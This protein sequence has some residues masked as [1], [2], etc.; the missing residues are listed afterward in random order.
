MGLRVRDWGLVGSAPGPPTHCIQTVHQV[1]GF[2]TFWVLLGL[3]LVGGASR[4]T[5]SRD[6]LRFAWG[7]VAICTDVLRGRVGSE[8]QHT[9]HKVMN[10]E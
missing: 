9:A 10:F 5:S 7:S 1:K 3:Y 6:D 2:S 4:Y 8:T